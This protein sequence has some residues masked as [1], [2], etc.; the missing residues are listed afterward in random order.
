MSIPVDVFRHLIGTG[1]EDATTELFAALLRLPRFWVAFATSLGRPYSL[2]ESPEIAT[3][4]VNDSGHGVPD[5]RIET[6]SA[7]LLVENKFAAPLTNNQPVEYLRTLASTVAQDPNRKRLL[8]LQAPRSRLAGLRAEVNDRI[9]RATTKRGP[10]WATGVDLA[11]HAWEDTAAAFAA[12]VVAN[13]VEAFCRDGFVVAVSLCAERAP[14]SLTAEMGDKLMKRDVLQAV[15]A[16]QDLLAAVRVLAKANGHSTADSASHN[17]FDCQ[18]FYLSPNRDATRK[19]WVGIFVRAGARFG[20]GP[21]W[22]QTVGPALTD[23]VRSSLA[24]DGVSTYDAEFDGWGNWLV[25]L[26]HVALGADAATAEAVLAEI[27]NIC[28][29]AKA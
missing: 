7:S 14:L 15:A 10:M 5:M 3:Q 26:N 12:V 23:A 8:V 16:L 25:P 11:L 24:S 22:L 17:R 21:L 4:F 1:R 19:V 18:G 29:A 6:G 27:L 20:H 9:A 2:G 13:P 28:D